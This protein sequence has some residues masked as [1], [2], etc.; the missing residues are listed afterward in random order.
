MVTRTLPLVP[1]TTLDTG[2]PGRP[3][4]RFTMRPRFS[5]P[6]A[7][8]VLLLAPGLAFAQPTDPIVYVCTPDAVI[9]K[10]V[11]TTS[12][13]LYTGT[14]RFDHCDVGPD[15]YLYV[16]NNLR[17]LRLDP[18][19][20]N[21]ASSSAEFV[22]PQLE[23]DGRGAAFNASTYYINTASSGVVKV[24]TTPGVPLGFPNSYTQLT[25]TPSGV[26]RDLLFDVSG[27]LIFI[28]D[29][30]VRRI[31]PPNY[32]GTTPTGTST[33][34]V[35]DSAF[36]LA[37]DTCRQVVY[38]DT[39]NRKVNRIV[40]IVDLFLRLILALRC[41]RDHRHKSRRRRNPEIPLDASFDTQGRLIP[42]GRSECEWHQHRQ[43]VPIQSG[44]ASGHSGR[45]MR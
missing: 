31:T 25:P 35:P 8:A 32:L 37:L 36:G 6:I 7:L 9:Y 5:L 13:K 3:W 44:V 45:H 42:S 11:G 10:V 19:S 18:T 21:T 12:T 22:G 26:G 20:K 2:G 27:N 33:Q 40:E 30:A 41:F 23:T 16:L 39:S 38:T 4:K 43:A 28:L 24:T 15:G 14:G 17:I 1:R 34:L 29:G